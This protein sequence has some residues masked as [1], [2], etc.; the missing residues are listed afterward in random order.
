M[1]LVMRL[2]VRSSYLIL[3][4]LFC[5]ILRYFLTVFLLFVLLFSYY[6]VCLCVF[7][8]FIYDFGDEVA[9]FL[10]IIYVMVSVWGLV[11]GD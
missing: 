6:R 5:D 9:E 8:E 2:A 1:C 11:M 7:D 10:L 4:D 3:Q